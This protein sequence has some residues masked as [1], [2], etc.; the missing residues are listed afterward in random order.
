MKTFVILIFTL[1]SAN[2]V[3]E[4]ADEILKKVDENMS[5]DNRVVEPTSVFLKASQVWLR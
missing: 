1:L 2:L 3:T 4:T 5:A